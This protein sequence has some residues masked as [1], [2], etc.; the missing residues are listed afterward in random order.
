MSRKPTSHTSRK[1]TSH[2]SRKAISRER[3]GKS[4][5]THSTTQTLWDA[6]GA[7]RLDQSTFYLPLEIVAAH[8]CSG[9]RDWDDWTKYPQWYPFFHHPSITE[10]GTG[11]ERHWTGLPLSGPPPKNFKRD[12]QR[13]LKDG[14]LGFVI[15]PPEGLILTCT[16]GAP[17]F[18]ASD[19]E[20]L[21]RL[22]GRQV[23]NP[24][25]PSV[26]QERPSDDD[27]G[28]RLDM[29]Y[30]VTPRPFLPL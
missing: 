3:A 1:A 15:V 7:G 21:A 11:L 27:N 10:T 9:L 28:D 17:T 29:S 8:T 13:A 14:A 20:V 24:G 26:F 30:F 12:H 2:T 16:N 22:N 6:L 18:S 19:I 5:R 23:A 4:T 25:Q